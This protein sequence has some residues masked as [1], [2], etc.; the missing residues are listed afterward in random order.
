M[1]LINFHFKQHSNY[2]LIVAANR[3][4]FYNRPT[5]QAHT[6]KDTPS[7]IAGRDLEKMG[8]WLG[9]TKNG[10]FAALTN[11]RDPAHMGAS[12]NSRGALVS[13]FLKNDQTPQQYIHAI[14]QEKDRFNGFNLLLGTAD[15][16]MYYNNIENEAQ[17]ITP[18][19]HSL[20]NHFLNTPWPKV[21]K[22]KSLLQNYIQ[23]SEKIDPE[24]LFG[25]LSN[26]V[27]AQDEDLPNTG[28]GLSLERQLSPL[29]IRM[30]D[31]GTRCSTVLL[32]T[33]DN[34]VQ[35][36]ERTFHKGLFTS[37]KKF[38]FQLQKTN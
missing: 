3:D 1:C 9:L 5:A 25:F 8:T 35:F 32:I 27:L 14:E 23:Q 16:L 22:G 20:S 30:E 28:V 10:R 6:W 38:D 19:T 29:F 12:K 31:Y 13:N 37:E 17:H 26:D 34:H 21:E 36:I 2:K 7:I 18:G 15:S 33:K 24:I 11:Y 4:E